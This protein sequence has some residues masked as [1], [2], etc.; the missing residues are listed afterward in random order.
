MRAMQGEIVS[1]TIRFSAF[2]YLLGAFFYL[3]RQTG[4]L[5]L[6]S[7]VM[8]NLA[9]LLL[10]G[11]T[12]DGY[13]VSL[14]FFEDFMLPFFWGLLVLGLR[15]KAAGRPAAGGLMAYAFLLLVAP[16]ESVEPTV[17]LTSAWAAVFFATEALTAA[18]VFAAA[19]QAGVNLHG[20]KPD[21]YDGTL[22]LWAFVVFTLCQIA[23][24]VWA[25]LGWSY[26]FSW[27]D[28]HL[29]SA[30]LWCLLAALLHAGYAGVPGRLR[31]RVC[32]AAVIPMFYLC[33][34]HQIKAI[35]RAFTG[36]SG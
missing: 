4:R 32:V 7:A 15:Q 17:K 29:A 24:A 12:A 2:F 6:A 30:S 14:I 21:R 34:L 35:V 8:L 33:G 9:A 25:Y 26:A 5:L 13:F 20:G 36:V 22:V 1:W 16:V 3:R 11:W 18:L 27:S 19:C 23:G 10:R 28:R 31:N